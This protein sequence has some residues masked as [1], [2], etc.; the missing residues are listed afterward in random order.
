MTRVKICGITD[1]ED[2]STAV[3]AGADSVGFVTEV[4]VDTPRNL[5]IRKAE[6]LVKETPPFVTSTL[7]IMPDSVEGAIDLV[8]RASPDLV[9]VHNYPEPDDVARLSDETE[10]KVVKKIEPDTD[11]M[12]RYSGVVDAFLVDSSD[13]QGGGGTGE[14]HDWSKT[15]E[16]VERTHIPVVLAGGLT[17]QN[18]GDAVESVHP[19]GVDVSSGVESSG[20]EKSP[21][22]VR[23][24]VEN[25]RNA[26]PGQGE[27]GEYSVRRV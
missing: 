16:I 6:Q 27:R 2:L 8:G 17:P 14:T 25:V 3:N 1:R 24:F 19:Y 12:E 23:G 13:E 21:D 11:E 9:Q 5:N 22:L 4:P 20:G 7:V 15:S 18:V 10:T 26:Q